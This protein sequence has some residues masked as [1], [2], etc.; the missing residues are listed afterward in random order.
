MENIFDSKWDTDTPASNNFDLGS[1]LNKIGN[2]NIN[3]MQGSSGNKLYDV[4]T[5][6]GSALMSANPQNKPNVYYIDSQYRGNGLASTPLRT[7]ANKNNYKPPLTWGET[8]R[9]MYRMLN[10]LSTQSGGS[11]GGL[12]GTDGNYYGS[13]TYDALSSV[14]PSSIFSEAFGGNNINSPMN[15][16]LGSANNYSS[17]LGN[18][19]TLGNSVGDYFNVSDYGGI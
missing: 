4:F 9:N 19:S 16:I 11:L 3:D 7:Q 14:M 15:S 12:L 18:F 17:G 1:V 8:M 10:P 6:I 5:G 2:W 13:H